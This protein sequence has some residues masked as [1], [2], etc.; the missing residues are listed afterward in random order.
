MGYQLFLISDTLPTLTSFHFRF[1]LNDV[2]DGVHRDGVMNGDGDD[3]HPSD[4]DHR[5]VT[6]RC[7][8]YRSLSSSFYDKFE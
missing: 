8:R 6:G 2:H 4:G 5:C 1:H 7:H 3:R